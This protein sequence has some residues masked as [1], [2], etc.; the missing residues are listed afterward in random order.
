MRHS[1]SI[2]LM[3]TVLLYSRLLAVAGRETSMQKR[4]SARPWKR[5]LYWRSP[6]PVTSRTSP[7]WTKLLSHEE[8]C[9]II[10][11]RQCIPREDKLH[12]RREQGKE[13]N[14]FRFSLSKTSSGLN[15]PTAATSMKTSLKNRLRNI[16]NFFAIIL[17]R[18]VTQKKWILAGA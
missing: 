12:R 10:C 9:W 17:I 8:P 15:D 13:N 4:P 14:V 6:F 16:L 1:P 2:L 5:I 18:P 3:L 11:V 7:Y